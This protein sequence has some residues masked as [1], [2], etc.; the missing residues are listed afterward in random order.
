MKV[1]VTGGAGFLGSH[2]A[3]T[4]LQNGHE[5]VIW[6]NL[7]TGRTSNIANLLKE[8]K[9][10]FETVDIRH[11]VPDLDV[12]AIIN[13]ACPA[14]PPH[15]QTD[16]VYTWETSILGTRNL[17]NLARQQ[18]ALFMQASTSEVYGDPIEH[19]QKETYW[20][21]V[22]T[23]GIR[24]CYD[25]GKRAAETLIM[26]YHRMYGLD[27]RIFRIFNTYGPRM[28]PDDGRVV[29][30]FCVQAIRRK[31][32][33]IYG[34]GKQSRSFCYVSDLIRGIYAYL[35]KDESSLKDHR[36][37]NLGNPDEFTILELAEA[38]FGML[39]LEK[40]T[41]DLPMPADDP[42][43]RRPDISLANEILGW[44][45]EV[46]LREGLIPTIEYFRK[47]IEG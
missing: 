9:V 44:K 23:V 29:S 32:L 13:M 20:G 37:I 14:S 1:L 45:P 30:N 12:D 8:H 21:N 31:P 19:P 40:N 28:H 24:S 36:V 10:L 5:V 26:D 47:E 25:E 34:G 18:K 42:K 27:V 38:V 43:R 2:L 7:N 35:M 22:N 46:S 41:V 15:Y 11:P 33:T 6:D 3:D 4:L 16:P 39:S 17:L